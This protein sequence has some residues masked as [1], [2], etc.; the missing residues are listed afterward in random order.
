MEA[1]VSEAKPPL[2]YFKVSTETVERRRHER[3]VVART[4]ED[5]LAE[6]ENG[7]AWPSDYDSHTVETIEEHPTKIEDGAER[8]MGDPNDLANLHART[9]YT[10]A[11][12]EEIPWPDEGDVREF[13]ARGGYDDIYGDIPDGAA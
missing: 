7:T 5:A 11:L 12:A 1:E 9:Y 3:L 8:G 10:K 4:P 2:K 13:E 6:Y